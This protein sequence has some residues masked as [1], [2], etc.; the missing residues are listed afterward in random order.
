MSPASRLIHNPLRSRFPDETA[1]AANPVIITQNRL[2]SF[3]AE[4]FSIFQ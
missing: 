1:T 2:Y 3:Y 4:K